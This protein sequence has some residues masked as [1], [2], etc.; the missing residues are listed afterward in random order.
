MRRNILIIRAFVKLREVLA[1]HKDLADK[2]AALEKAQK[3][4]GATIGDILVAVN[5]LIKA[6]RRLP[7]AIGQDGLAA[8]MEEKQ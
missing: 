3:Q 7:P 5:M 4:Q 6:H 1:S 2:I 8:G